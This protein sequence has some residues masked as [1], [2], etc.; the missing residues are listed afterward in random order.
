MLHGNDW[1]ASLALLELNT[2]LL[3]CTSPPD[4]VQLGFGGVLL[5]VLGWNAI[6]TSSEDSKREFECIGP[7]GI[8]FF[9]LLRLLHARH[10]S[11]KLEFI[12]YFLEAFT[13]VCG[14]RF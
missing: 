13:S 11:Y 10:F 8:P 9:D 14:I 7:S 2:A 1:Q 3:R 4:K 6:D 12:K 5:M